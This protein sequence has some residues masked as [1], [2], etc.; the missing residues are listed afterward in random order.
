MGQFSFKTRKQ[1]TLNM[2]T[3]LAVLAVI[4][5]STQALPQPKSLTCDICIDLITD[6]DEWLTSDATE[7]EIL[8]YAHELCHLLDSIL[9][10]LEEA[11]NDLFDTQLPTIIDGLVNDNLNPQEVCAS[12]AMCP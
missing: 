7:E 3:F 12:V 4:L 11:C 1:Y 5:A 6:I 8:S 9:S 2:K 10:A